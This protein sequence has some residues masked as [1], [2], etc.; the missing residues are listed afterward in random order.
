[1]SGMGAWF[2]VAMIDLRGSARRF[3]ILVA[4]LALGVAAIGA[5]SSVGS[6]L[7]SAIERDSRLILG[8]DLEVRARGSDIGAEVRAALEALGKVSREVELNSRA[9]KGARSVFLSLRSVGSNYPLVGSVGLGHRASATSIANLLAAIDGVPGVLLAPQAVQRLEVAIGDTVRIGVVDFEL[10]GTIASLPDQVTQG[11]QLGA[12]AIIAEQALAASGLAQDGVLTS[13]RYKLDLE[14]RPYASAQRELEDRFPVRAWQI[15]SPQDAT[16]GISRFFRILRNFLALVGLSSLFV[17]GLG[18]SNA[19]AAYIGERQVSIATMRSMGA[20]SNRLSFHFLAQVLV[21]SLLG[22]VLGLAGVVVTTMLAL[23][24]LSGALGLPLEASVDLASIATSGCIGIVAAV[25]FAWIPLRAIHEIRPAMLFRAGSAGITSRLAWRNLR[26]PATWVPLFAGLTLLFA[27]TVAITGDPMLVLFY[28]LGLSAALGL[29]RLAASAIRHGV[30]R[31]PLSNNRRTRMAISAIH[32]PGAPTTT[33]VVSLGMGLALL[34]VVILI[35]LSVTNHIAGEIATQAPAFVLLD[36]DQTARRELENFAKADR[37]ITEFEAVPMLRGTITAINGTA[38]PQPG[39]VPNDVADMF[40]G[41]TPMSWTRD[42]SPG[43]Q[44]VMGEWWPADYSGPPLVSLSTEMKDS[45]HLGLGDTLEIT[46]LGR[47]LSVTV[48]SFRQIDWRSPQFNFRILLSPGLIEYAPQSFMGG[49]KVATGA[50]S[51]V[52]SDLVRAFPSVSLIPV[53]EALARARSIIETIGRAIAL[54]GGVAVL[55]G[56]LVL[57]GALGVGR[58]Q[59]EADAVV[60]KVLGST[61][62]DVIE[63]FLLEYL[64]L[65][66]LAAGMASIIAM[67][68]A[69]ALS[70]FLLELDFSVDIGIV[71]V[72][73]LCA[74]VLTIGT[75]ALTTWSAMSAGPASRLRTGS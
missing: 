60:M 29:L 62:R 75:G 38:A 16:A 45:L 53:G 4:C 47:P 69:W 67:V 71:V 32:R 15:R 41:D 21:L 64:V 68:G 24:F 14:G 19:V 39:D 73:S 57:A 5:V 20:S 72:I 54:L 30:A 70:T 11:F 28:S 46:V 2:K 25:V 18:I 17:G 26:R 23:P 7:R 1:M 66:L 56:M 8:G 63:T 55:A 40:R 44:V 48:A 37:R 34:V 31:L 51:A 65:G 10:R 6:M 27:L 74:I 42:L 13:Y 58:E 52:E 50:E 22:V 3:I 33:V 61:R 12:P 43:S 35:Q 9:V 49:I 59:R 36:V